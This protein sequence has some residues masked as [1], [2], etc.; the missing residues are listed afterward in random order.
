MSMKHY[1]ANMRIEENFDSGKNADIWQ[2]VRLDG[3][4]QNP[5]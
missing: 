3:L 5:K 4:F 1:F 2:N